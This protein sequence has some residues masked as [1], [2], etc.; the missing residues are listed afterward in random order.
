MSATLRMRINAIMSWRCFARNLT[1]K[2][3]LHS[4]LQAPAFTMQT[5]TFIEGIPITL[6]L[7]FTLFASVK[8]QESGNYHYILIP[9]AGCIC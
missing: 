3:S 7:Y 4:L 5:D 9:V 6:D 2:L 1:S 8:T